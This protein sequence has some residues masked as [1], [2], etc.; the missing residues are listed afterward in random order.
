MEVAVAVT[1][2]HWRHQWCPTVAAEE[3]AATPAEDRDG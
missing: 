1:T 2:R 3:E